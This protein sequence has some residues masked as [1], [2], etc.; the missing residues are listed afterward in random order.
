MTLPYA[1]EGKPWA[2]PRQWKND[3]ILMQFCVG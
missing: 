1:E 2:L 3:S